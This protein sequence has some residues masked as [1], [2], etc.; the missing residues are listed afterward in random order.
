[1]GFIVAHCPDAIHLQ[2]ILSAPLILNHYNFK[3]MEF[4]VIFERQFPNNVISTDFK[5]VGLAG[6]ALA[7]AASC[8][9]FLSPD[10]V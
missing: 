5:E 8:V 6:L 10:R 7:R 2:G 9:N 3:N 4:K 1:L